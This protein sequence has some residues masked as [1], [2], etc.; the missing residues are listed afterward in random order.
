M[1]WMI[2][3][4]KCVHEKIK[5]KNEKSQ[6]SNKKNKNEKRHERKMCV[7]GEENWDTNKVHAHIQREVRRGN[8]KG[9]GKEKKIAGEGN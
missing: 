9:R 6:R 1:I 3:G 7:K 4:T 5:N 8:G 2:Q